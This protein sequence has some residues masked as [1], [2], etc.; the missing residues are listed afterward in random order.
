VSSTTEIVSLD[1]LSAVRVGFEVAER[2]SGRVHRG[3]DMR[4]VVPG[5]PGSAFAGAVTAIDSRIDS[6]SRTLRLEATIDDEGQALKP[7]MSVKVEIAFASEERLV[8][9]SLAVQWDRGG[10]FI[11]KLD[12]DTVRRADVTI[13]RRLSGAAIVAG[14]VDAGD[15]VVVEGVQRLRDGAT[16]AIL[17]EETRP[18][19]PLASQ[20]DV[21]P[22]RA[23]N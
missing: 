6:A 2:W 18:D 11:W 8:V 4:A 20:I 12:G 7:G 19:V 3:L 13:V 1:D 16:V 14:D 10:S 21:R 17:G 23:R 22:D 9:P 15:R 5:L